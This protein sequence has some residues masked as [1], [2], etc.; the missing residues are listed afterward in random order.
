MVTELRRH[1]VR[2]RCG[3]R[4]RAAYD[5][6]LL[7]ASPFGPRLHAVVAMLS[8]VYHLGRRKV[9]RLLV[10][11]FDVHIS[12]GGLSNMEARVSEALAPATE[13]AQREVEGAAV[14][15]ID[16]TTWLRAGALMSLW[17]LASSLATVYRI[18]KDGRRETVRSLFERLEGVLVSDRASVFGFWKIGRRQICWAHLLRK[19]VSFSERDGP[20][21]ALGRDLLDCARLVFEYWRGFVEGALSREKLGAWLAPVQK[22]ASV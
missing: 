3:Q 14:K 9:Q 11:L 15:H 8:G 2:C 22:Q 18:V 1:E 10:E 20:V 6:E 19:F 21:G 17:T 16:A 5:K 13:A 4:T 12:L 7:P